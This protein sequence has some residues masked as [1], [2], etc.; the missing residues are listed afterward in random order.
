LILTMIITIL[1]STYGII[2]SQKLYRVMSGF[3]KVFEKKNI[4]KERK[5]EKTYDAI[6]FGYNRI[7]FN[8]LNSLKKVKQKYLVVDFNP[9]TIYDLQKLQ[10]PSLYGDVD[11][12]EFLQELPLA[13]MKLG[14]STVP[15]F[16]TNE[17][18]I[19]EI[20]AVNPKAIIIVRAHTIKEAFDL[21]SVGASYVLTPHFLGGEYISKM[22]KELKVN[23]KG[24][25][26]EKKKHI[27]MLEK[28]ADKGHDHPKV[29]RD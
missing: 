16:E 4:K 19:R 25:K 9:D 22:I 2:Y 23:S 15:D 12:S 27:K 6:L 8:I 10:I 28:M 3:L 5:T 17:L 29:E 18:L 11:D 14:V 20:R 7:G 26:E 13:K 21:Y 24:Y 1:L